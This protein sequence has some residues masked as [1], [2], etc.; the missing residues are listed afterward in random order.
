MDL[1]LADQT[2]VEDTPVVQEIAVSDILLLDT[3]LP[4]S[5]STL[6]VLFSLPP[7]LLPHFVG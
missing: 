5:G 6:Y 4:V 3:P 2:L 7:L 1:D